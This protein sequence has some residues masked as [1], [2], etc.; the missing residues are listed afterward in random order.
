[1]FCLKQGRQQ[2]SN[3]ASW[4]FFDRLQIDPRCPV[5]AAPVT[6]LVMDHDHRFLTKTFSLRQRQCHLVTTHMAEWKGT[7]NTTLSYEQ[8]AL[9]HRHRTES[10]V[11]SVDP[12]QVC[13]RPAENVF[14]HFSENWPE[15][16]DQLNWPQA[17]AMNRQK[18]SSDT[19]SVSHINSALIYNYYKIGYNYKYITIYHTNSLGK[20]LNF[21]VTRHLSHDLI[22][23]LCNNTL[24]KIALC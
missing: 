24:A 21:C 10:W 5:Q 13:S 16:D 23:M 15:V 6:E 17:K 8:K 7:K 1:M 2:W 22:T 9:C 4:F 12:R 18:T 3:T 14:W 11:N 20:S 19:Q